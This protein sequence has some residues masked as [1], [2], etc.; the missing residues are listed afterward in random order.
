MT[1]R[2]FLEQDIYAYLHMKKQ[3]KRRQ[4]VNPSDD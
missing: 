2:V 1:L 4:A 3:Y